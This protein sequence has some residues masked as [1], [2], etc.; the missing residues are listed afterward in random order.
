MGMIVVILLYA[1]YNT[2]PKD[3]MAH[4]VNVVLYGEKHT[5]CGV[6]HTANEPRLFMYSN[7]MPTSSTSR[8]F[9][10]LFFFFNGK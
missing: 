5:V 2:R 9:L 1:S 10:D 3:M 6:I 8:A 4:N 7:A